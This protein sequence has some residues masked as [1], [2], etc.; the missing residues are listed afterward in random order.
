MGNS[1]S[2]TAITTLI[3]PTGATTGARVVIDGTTGFITVYNAADQIVDTIGGP[4]GAI[5]VQS[6][7]AGQ[8]E[9]VNGQILF[10]TGD[11]QTQ[12]P[13]LIA[14]TNI[15]QL[16]IRS[17]SNAGLPL[18]FQAQLVFNQ[19]V[20]PGGVPTAVLSEKAAAAPTDLL[21][22]GAVIAANNAGTAYVW[23][24]P[25]GTYAPNWSGTGAFAG[26]GGHELEVRRMP[27]DNV[28]LY[29][30]ATTAAGAGTTVTTLPA[31]YFNTSVSTSGYVLR[32]RGGAIAAFPLAVD[33]A[34]GNVVVG[35]VPAAGDQYSFN[36]L[37]PLGNIA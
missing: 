11:I 25:P 2:N 8:V 35:S 34:T 24:D 15:G 33:N 26:L 22:G 14:S 12:L 9:L 13:G 1:W 29:G 23:Q 30:Y 17:G 28:W 6:P 3:I 21:V 7:G 4:A 16:V 18:N 36:V 20:N 27:D 32:N 31:G 5:L 10:G 37:M 19:A